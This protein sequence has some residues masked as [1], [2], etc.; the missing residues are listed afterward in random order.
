METISTRP[1]WSTLMPVMLEH[2]GNPKIRAEFIR[3]ATI[4]DTFAQRREGENKAVEEIIDLLNTKCHTDD[5]EADHSLA[6][7]LLCELLA[8]M[9]HTELVKTYRAVHKWY[10]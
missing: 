9:G 3:L 10:A 8:A 6:D 2:A 7:E 4:A 1:N 5:C